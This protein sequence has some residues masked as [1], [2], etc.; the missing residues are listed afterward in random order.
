MVSSIVKTVSNLL[1]DKNRSHFK[2]EPVEGSSN[3]FTSNLTN[4]QQV[5]IK[6][7]TMTFHIIKGNPINLY[8]PDFSYFIT[9]TQFDKQRQN[10]QLIFYFLNM[11]YIINYGDEKSMRYY[12]I[13][14]L[15]H[16]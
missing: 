14:D 9:N 4:P 12:F 6:G 8:D 13:K 5:Q 16:Q 3:L 1:N 11:K 15:I 7:S 2:L 10:K